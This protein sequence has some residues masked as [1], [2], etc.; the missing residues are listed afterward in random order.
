MWTLIRVV[1]RLPWSLTSAVTRNE[2]SLRWPH[3]RRDGYLAGVRLDGHAV[4]GRR[5]G[6]L[7]DEGDRDAG[8]VD[9]RLL[10][11]VRVDGLE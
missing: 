8:H 2:R 10:R 7:R 3:Q 11:S 9:Q 6:E 1:S 4:R 5:A